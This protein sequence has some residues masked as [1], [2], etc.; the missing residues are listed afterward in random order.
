MKTVADRNSH[1]H[2]RGEWKAK[3]EDDSDPPV[4]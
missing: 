3:P 4:R 1:I 2:H